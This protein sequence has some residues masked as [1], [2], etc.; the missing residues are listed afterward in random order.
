MRTTAEERC[1]WSFKLL[2]RALARNADLGHL[3]PIWALAE[4]CLTVV[5]SFRLSS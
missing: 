1:V 5:K 2:T 4:L 3:L